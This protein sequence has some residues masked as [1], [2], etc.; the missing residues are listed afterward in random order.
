M[1]DNINVTPG[2]GKTIA[3]DDVS[4]VLYQRVK[5][6][7]GV[8]G[9]ATDLTGES[10]FGE[11]ATPRSFI[12]VTLTLDTSA[13]ATGDV[14]ADTQVVSNAMRVADG[15]GTLQSIVV[16]DEDDQGIAFDVVFLSANVSLGTENAAVSIT[17]ANARNW[18]GLVSIAGGDYVDLGG[19][20]VAVKMNLGLVVKPATGTRDLYVGAIGR[21]TATYTAAGI[22]LRLGF[23]TS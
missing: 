13:Y 18:L 3:A 11:V 7:V 21:G 20:R 12:D 17:D 19:S 1:A 5:L 2:S 8:D 9:V 4:G 15:L 10:H 14:L 6:A 16:L 22:K 23:E